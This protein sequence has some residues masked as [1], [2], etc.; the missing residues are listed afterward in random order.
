MNSVSS[1]LILVSDSFAI[2]SNDGINFRGHREIEHH[3]DQFSEIIRS[4]LHRNESIMIYSV[5]CVYCMVLIQDV[6][7]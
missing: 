6:T 3:G 1:F 7:R 4:M 5:L 2:M